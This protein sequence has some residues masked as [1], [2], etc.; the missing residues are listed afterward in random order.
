MEA[1]NGAVLLSC[2]SAY[3]AIFK[4]LQ[5]GQVAG[6]YSRRQKEQGGCE[7]AKISCATSSCS[8][9]LCEGDVALP[10]LGACPSRRWGTAYRCMLRSL[11]VPRKDA[12]LSHL[13]DSAEM[14]VER[15]Q[16]QSSLNWCLIEQH[17]ENSICSWWAS[18]GS[19]TGTFA[20]VVG[21]LLLTAQGTKVLQWYFSRMVKRADPNLFHSLQKVKIVSMKQWSVYVTVWALQD[22]QDSHSTSNGRGCL[23]SEGSRLSLPET[24]RT[25]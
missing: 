14:P 3:W 25:I 13:L 23:R 10:W 5:L 15:C 4:W 11:S 2:P 20:S 6:C 18:A 1:R 7:K 19:T 22:W 12:F 21:L 24:T 16:P 17:L 8:I 9:Q